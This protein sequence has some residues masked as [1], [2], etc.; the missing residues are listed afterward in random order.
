MIVSVQGA[1][2]CVRPILLRVRPIL[3]PK[4]SSP[5]DRRQ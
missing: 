5:R 4:S 3:H 1:H 2:L